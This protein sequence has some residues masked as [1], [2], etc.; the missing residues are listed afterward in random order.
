MQTSSTSGTGKTIVH[1]VFSAHLDPIWLWPW[2]A[3]LDEALATFRSA[4]DRLDK[5]PD[6][7]FSFGEA[8]LYQQ[9]ERCDPQLFARMR[10]HIEAGRW[11][12]VGGWWVQPDCNLPSG[13]GIEKQMELGKK[14]FTERFGFFPRMGFN[15]DS[16]GHAATLPSIIHAGGQS[17]Y[18]MM[19]PQQQEMALDTNLFHWQEKP[20][21][22]AVTTLRLGES[23]GTFAWDHDPTGRIQNALACAAPGVGHALCI[24]GLSNHGGG[25]TERLIAWCRRNMDA[26]PDATLVFSTVE[27]FFAAV[28]TKAALLPTVTGELQM[29]AV[30]CYT[31]HRPGKIA[32]RRAEHRL[33][34]C[35][36]HKADLPTDPETPILL[37][38]GWENVCFHHFHDTLGGTC[39]PSAYVTVQDQL[40]QAASAADEAL[41]LALRKKLLALPPDPLQRIVL[42][43]ASDTAFDGYT[44]FETYPGYPPYPKHWH[45]IDEQDRPVPFQPVHTEAICNFSWKIFRPLVRVQIPPGELRVLRLKWTP[46]TV[47]AR[48]DVSDAAV[49]TNDV[50]ITCDLAAGTMESLHALPFSIPTLE[51]IADES[52]TWSHGTVRYEGDVQAAKWSAVKIVDRGPLMA[53]A[54]QTG[55]IGQSTLSAEWRVYAGESGVDLTLC[56]D[57]NE[58]HKILK[59]VLP[60]PATVPVDSHTDGIPGGSLQRPSN[61]H[62]VPVRDYLHF[63]AAKMAILCPDVLAGDVTPKQV[64]LSLLRSALLAHH[65]PYDTKQLP[66]PGVYSDRGE[67]TFRFRFLLSD[68]I[69][70]EKLEEQAAM[71]HRPPI[72][73][74]LTRGMLP[75]LPVE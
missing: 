39:L 36:L 17:A 6:L 13:F 71:Y 68:K 41:H 67:H 62:E 54:V 73:A 10:K 49:L 43:N 15:V 55:E 9:V 63:P 40:G 72:L 18:V 57:W 7:H 29:H 24:L 52:D 75:V 45:L 61:G 38:R 21:S 12:I 74:E 23:Y 28:E 50:G 47:E 2:T 42:W 20:G 48:V 3:G 30:G 33:H 25:P 53:S 5:H 58:H 32:L 8:A 35:D 69:T 46:E 70:V 65:V 26:F 1:L 31:V 64:R 19:R 14:Y 60:F 34:Q 66:M 37:R 51:L 27:R 22:P 11:E 56:I 4:C 59:L 44:E 16:F